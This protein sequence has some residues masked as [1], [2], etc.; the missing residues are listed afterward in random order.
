[1]GPIKAIKII[2]ILMLP[3]LI[4]LSVLNLTSFDESFYTREFSEQKVSEN[5]PDAKSLHQ[6]VMDFLKGGASQPPE[7]FNEKEKQH[8][9]DVK[10]LVSISTILLYILL[11]IFA[12]LLLASAFIIKVNNYLSNFIGRIFLIGGFLTILRKLLRILLQ[13]MF[14]LR[15]WLFSRYFWDGLLYCCLYTSFFW[16]L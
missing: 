12:A 2:L 1:M 14:R 8:L 13:C 4:F 3:L 16:N 11:F 5:V 9:I 6:K 10:R 7:G 15:D